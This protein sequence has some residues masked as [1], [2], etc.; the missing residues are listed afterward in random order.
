MDFGK[1]NT[2]RIR[3][4]F[5]LICIISLELYPVLEI[6]FDFF[7]KFSKSV[8]KN[9]SAV[10]KQFTCEFCKKLIGAGQNLVYIP[11]SDV[12]WLDTFT[13]TASDGLLLDEL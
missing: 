12:Y 11:N 9:T 10:D 5:I 13:F 8:L 2:D 6:I 1:S 7:S 4:Y 3:W